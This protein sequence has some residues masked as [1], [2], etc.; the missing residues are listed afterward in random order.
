MAKAAIYSQKIM[1]H[2]I[3]G[4]DT[5]TVR[6]VGE[7]QASSLEKDVRKGIVLVPEMTWRTKTIPASFY[8]VRQYRTANGVADSYWM[9][10]RKI[11]G[12]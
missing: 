11:E 10:G 3:P 6:N 9:L 7:W 5:L 8:A 12:I 4:A 2:L 1:G